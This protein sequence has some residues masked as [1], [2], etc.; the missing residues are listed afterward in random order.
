MGSILN[1]E[2]GNPLTTGELTE[3]REALNR[4]NDTFAASSIERAALHAVEIQG[5]DAMWSVLAET[6]LAM[7]E[8]VGLTRSWIKRG[9]VRKSALRALTPWEPFRSWLEEKSAT[10]PVFAEHVG[11]VERLRL[12]VE[13]TWARND[14]QA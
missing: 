7:D 1:D 5:G 11:A 12:L 9:A 13:N 2:N 8:V 10:Y 4:V 3:L 6:E 14:P